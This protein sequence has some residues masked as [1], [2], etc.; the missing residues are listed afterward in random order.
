MKRPKP[1]RRPCAGWGVLAG[2]ACDLPS[3]SHRLLCVSIR[4]WNGSG[5]L[6]DS[7]QIGRLRAVAEQRLPV[8]FVLIHPF[9]GQFVR[10]AG[11]LV[12][13]ELPVSHRQE[14]ATGSHVAIVFALLHGHLKRTTGRVK[15]TG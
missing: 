12:V 10:L 14:E 11:L 2:E 15:L 7:Q 6:S 5:L 13:A 1:A 4:V 8:R 3:L 9:G